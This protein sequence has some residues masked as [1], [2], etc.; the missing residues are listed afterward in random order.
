M[1]KYV[2]DSVA[3]QGRK[4]ADR[5]GTNL[6][7]QI[8]NVTLKNGLKGDN[9]VNRLTESIKGHNGYIQNKQGEDGDYKQKQNTSDVQIAKILSN[10]STLKNFRE[11]VILHL[12]KN[13]L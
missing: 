2:F 4:T 3:K 12:R 6:K 7:D 10:P 5:N 1:S 8:K 13:D 9:Y 11:L